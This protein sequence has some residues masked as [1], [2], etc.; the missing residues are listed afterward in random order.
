MPARAG[1]EAGGAHP[2]SQFV[3]KV[4][5]RCDLKCDHCYVYE[6]ADQSW[7]TKARAMSADV[8]RAA[9]RRIAEHAA[10]WELP[11]VR[12]VVHGGEPLLL[13]P[14]GLDRLITEI[15]TPIEKVTRLSL[16]MQTNGV[17]FNP[18]T[19]DVLKRHG[20]RVGVSLDGDREANDRHRRFANG[21]G[22]FD[23]VQAALALLRT[24][25]YREL[26]AGLLC[27]IDIRNSPDRV[28]E[29]LLAER[30]PA[31]DFLLPHAT[32]ENPP[33]RPD[34]D[35]TPYA[36][37][38]SVIHRRWLADGRPMRIRLFDGLH[39]TARGG[40]SGSEQL[41]ADTVDMVVIETGGE[42]EQADSVKT[43]YDGA[44]ATGLSVLTHPVDE[45][46]RLRPIA[47]RQRGV[48]GLNE[49]CR[50]CPVVQQCAGGLYAHRF[51]AGHGFDNPSVYCAD[52]RV[53]IDRTNEETRMHQADAK[54]GETG[55]ADVIDQIA[56]GFGDEAT[57]AWLTGQQHAVT[58]ALVVAAVEQHGE[59][60]GWRALTELE[61]GHAGAVRH[62]LAHPY[63]RAWAVG[64]LRTGDAAGLPYLGGLAA[65]AAVHASVP[66]ETDV[67]I[68]QGVVTLPTVGTLYWPEPVT[69]PARI[70]ADPGKLRLTGPDGVVLTV[71][72]SQPGSTA[73]WQPARHIA[74]DGWSVRIEDGDPARDCH[75]W[76]PAARL[77]DQAVAQW[78]DS[79]TAAWRL[80]DV[81]LPEYAP[82]LRAGLKV[83][84]PL[85]PDPAGRQRAS[86]AMDA[87]GSLSAVPVGPAELAVLLVH[88]F[89]HA[90]LG[91][92]LDLYD[93][94]DPDSDARITV[95]W[96][97]ESRP[98]E[99]ALQGVYAHAAVADVW[100]RRVGH[101]PRAPEL[102]AM[103]HRWTVDAVAALRET[104]ALTPLGA[105]FV[106]RMAATIR[107]WDS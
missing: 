5:G 100:R 47:V 28:Y 35:P 88:E 20:V 73:H 48:A 89:Q 52:L 63:V 36:T 27:T 90:K 12:V 101:D 80:I 67:R 60:A 2:L 87:F 18:A 41:G 69:A 102:Y 66:V 75:G 86:T 32:W 98:V 58:R 44:P 46:S 23:Q 59:T 105:A 11:R 37:W 103:Y 26:Y 55:P 83:I 17:R 25:A 106:D 6:H 1:D 85:E 97:T 3:L 94:H 65:A 33:P 13:G 71:D 96:K 81:E 15:R 45:V 8:A 99:A 19:G 14:A 4:H 82:A 38:L 7:M 91:A 21:A 24:P 56:S 57:I 40:R 30:P 51:R 79:L 43:A 78:R 93:L 76:T 42:Y 92:L 9:A 22:S 34:G 29:A 53:L 95:G 104:G 54:P 62:V 50:S 31:V 72:L 70:A 16:T 84:M 77:D 74:R 68:E 107:S 61:E 39:S 64:M 10:R 49:I